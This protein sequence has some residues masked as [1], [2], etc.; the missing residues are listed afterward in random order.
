MT[1]ICIKTGWRLNLTSVNFSISFIV[2]TKQCHNS[3]RFLRSIFLIHTTYSSLH[4]K[5]KKKFLFFYDYTTF[6]WEFLINVPVVSHYILKL[7][8][9]SQHISK[10]TERNLIGS[11]LTVYNLFWNKC[12]ILLVEM[13]IFLSFLKKWSFR[14]FWYI[15][16]K[17]LF[18]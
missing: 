2:Y 5:R 4:G 7:K 17:V 16:L 11:L 9:S 3:N 12:F 8:T 6:K 10:K 13:L 14:K 18:L 15:S 1:S